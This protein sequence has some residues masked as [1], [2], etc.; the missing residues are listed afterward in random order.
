MSH[1]SQRIA[2][3]NSA[4]LFTKLQFDIVHPLSFTLTAPPHVPLAFLKVMLFNFTLAPRTS[5]IFA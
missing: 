3:P 2:P 1:A 5:K 4:V